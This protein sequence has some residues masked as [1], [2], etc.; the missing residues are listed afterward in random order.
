MST[1]ADAD[2]CHLFIPWKEWAKDLSSALEG[3]EGVNQSILKKMGEQEFDNL[4]KIENRINDQTCAGGECE[5]MSWI[6]VSDSFANG[7][8]N[9]VLTGGTFQG[10][11]IDEWEVVASQG[12]PPTFA[13]AGFGTVTLNENGWYHIS[14]SVNFHHVSGTD[15]VYPN[16]HLFAEDLPMPQFN[17]AWQQSTVA[18]DGM[19]GACAVSASIPF[20]AGDSFHTAGYLRAP[21]AATR[22]MTIDATGDN[23][24]AFMS[25]HKLCGCTAT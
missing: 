13:G 23:G 25:I 21:T 22:T 16:I 7:T 3:V 11:E 14:V 5:C 12:T 4:K 2:R 17:A 24:Y 1:V 8:S 6:G 9:L 20:M 15:T 19:D 10:S 18:A